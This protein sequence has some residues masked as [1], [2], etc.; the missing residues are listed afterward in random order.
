MDPIVTRSPLQLYIY[1]CTFRNN[2][3]GVGSI[4]TNDAEST[5]PLPSND[6]NGTNSNMGGGGMS[7][8]SRGEMFQAIGGVVV[9]NQFTSRGGGLAVIVNDA[10]P[11]DVVVFGCLFKENGALAFGGGMYLGLDGKSRHSVII[12]QTE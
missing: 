2:S 5:D 9:G 7:P 12:N 11:A 6:G 4:A 10:E 1:N 3:V 8:P